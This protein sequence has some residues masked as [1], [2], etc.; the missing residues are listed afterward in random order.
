MNLE[1]Q[2]HVPTLVELFK[3]TEKDKKFLSITQLI[4]NIQMFL[5][6]RFNEEDLQR[7]F[8][9]ELTYFCNKN[10]DND[11]Y[12]KERLPTLL[13]KYA[14]KKERMDFLFD[15][16]KN[17]PYFPAVEVKAIDEY[18]VEVVG[19]ESY[20]TNKRDEVNQPLL[21]I[22]NGYNVPI[23]GMCNDNSC[24]YEV[25][26]FLLDNLQYLNHD[27]TVKFSTPLID[28]LTKEILEYINKED[29]I[30]A[31]KV[32]ISKYNINMSVS[33]L[34][35]KLS[36]SETLSFEDAPQD[37]YYQ[38]DSSKMKFTIVDVGDK[39][40]PRKQY[41][42]FHT[43]LDEWDFLEHNSDFSDWEN[44]SNEL[45]SVDMLENYYFEPD[46][47]CSAKEVACEKYQE[48]MIAEEKAERIAW[49]NDY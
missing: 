38:L 25:K 33:A 36:N 40:L 14:N 13:N 16:T 27:I 30:Y 49:E 34:S 8:I 5:K 7:E 31:P 46:I 11:N 39:I 45:L 23:T 15:N 35:V 18:A 42:C 21:A 32:D 24:P 29:F 1:Y 19:I 10:T 43:S 22:L 44:I 26:T 37:Y 20:Y 41:V 17:P 3:L 28:V 9:G 47:L 4:G 6:T 12:W 48:R 2:N